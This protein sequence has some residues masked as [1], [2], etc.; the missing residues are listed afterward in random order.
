MATEKVTAP[1]NDLPTGNSPALDS[2]RVGILAGPT[3]M[4]ELKASLLKLGA[5]GK[6]KHA[7][8]ALPPLFP[9]KGVREGDARLVAYLGFDVVPAERNTGGGGASAVLNFDVHDHSKAGFPVSHRAQMWLNATLE[10]YFGCKEIE[11]ILASKELQK[12][13]GTEQ[14]LGEVREQCG[15][16]G[17]VMIPLR[18]PEKTPLLIITFGGQGV[19]KKTGFAP[20]KRWI[21]EEFTPAKN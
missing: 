4:I 7:G 5:G 1:K 8:G 17:D 20:A 15:K 11:K 10:S 3:D 19:T 6:I 14:R 21:I 2:M 18:D 9:E 16:E 12:T 13:L